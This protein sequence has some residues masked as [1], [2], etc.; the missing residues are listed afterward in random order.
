MPA[1][2]DADIK[3]LVDSNSADIDWKTPIERACKET[4]LSTATVRV[5]E[6]VTKLKILFPVGDD[7]I[8]ECRPLVKENPK[9]KKFLV[10]QN[11]PLVEVVYTDRTETLTAPFNMEI[12][13]FN[14]AFVSEFPKN[15][16]CIGNMRVSKK[17]QHTD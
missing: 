1:A 8:I 17:R 16:L 9:N 10:N 11:E 15:Y 7:R 5:F 13:A 4:E 3:R 2:I 14:H 6:H 12:L